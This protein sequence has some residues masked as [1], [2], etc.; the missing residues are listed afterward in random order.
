MDKVYIKNLK[1]EAIIGIFEWE[2]EVKQIIS[3]DIEMDFDNKKAA[4]SDD[5]E[6]ALD[7]KKVGKRVSAFIQGSK[8][9][10]VESLAEKV[11]KII[12]QEFPVSRLVLTL[13]KPGALRGSES[14]GISITRP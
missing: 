7:Y 8:V 1:V 2:R 4:T 6:D 11:A 10:L 9:K 5:I 13:S 14:V 3:V 12:L